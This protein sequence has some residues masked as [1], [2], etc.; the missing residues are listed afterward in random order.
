MKECLELFKGMW[1]LATTEHIRI[2]ALRLKQRILPYDA[3]LADIVHKKCRYVVIPDE[4]YVERKITC[5]AEKLILA[6]LQ[7][8]ARLLQNGEALFRKPS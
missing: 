2:K 6:L 8:N 1:V 4:E 3:K 5:L 7:R